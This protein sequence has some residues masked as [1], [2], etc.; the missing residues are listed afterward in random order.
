MRRDWKMSGKAKFYPEAEYN[1]CQVGQLHW[2]NNNNYEQSIAAVVCD[3]KPSESVE[4]PSGKTHTGNVVM[5]APKSEEQI[6]ME[7]E[8]ARQA[9]LSKLTEDERKLLGVK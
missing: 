4:Y 9:V 6:K 2:I 1:G 5:G 3:G 7:Q 8:A